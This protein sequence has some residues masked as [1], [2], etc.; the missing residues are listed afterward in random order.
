[1]KR[2]LARIALALIAIIVILCFGGRWYLARSVMTYDGAVKAGVAARVEITFDARGIPQV[3]AKTDRDAYFAIGYLHASERLFQMELVR[4]LARGE[5]SEVFGEAAYETD[6]FQ[7][8]VGFARR[9]KSSELSAS[10]RA[11]MQSYVD[12][13]NAGIRTATML[14]PELAILRLTPR[15]WTLDDCLAISNYQTWFS[16]QLMDQDEKYQKIIAKLG[17]PGSALA[18]AG[19]PWSPPTIPD[20]R[21][22]NASN[23]WVLAPTRSSTKA[24]LHAAD[25]H[26]SIDQVPGLW[27]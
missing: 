12:G 8:R 20:M 22:T 1:M 23:S 14:P 24:A 5:L 25:P 7:R 26:L 19:H 10:T 9:A 16:H 15:P 11:T 18:N 4:R 6:V 27:Y 3:W 2:W 13:V 21:I 17:M